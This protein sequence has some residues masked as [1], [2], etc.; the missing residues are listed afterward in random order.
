MALALAVKA[1]LHPI[2]LGGSQNWRLHRQFWWGVLLILILMLLLLLLLLWLLAF[3]FC[4]WLLTFCSPP[5]F[6]WGESNQA[7]FS[8]DL[9]GG[10]LMLLL[11][12][13]LAFDLAFF[14]IHAK[15]SNGNI[16]G[17]S[18]KQHQRQK[19]KATSKAKAKGNPTTPTKAEP[20]L[21][22]RLC[23]DSP[24]YAVE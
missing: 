14:L 4:F 12:F 1:L 9:V 16:K 5:C 15:K 24:A 6:I 2:F 23:F 7:A 17:K 8:P 13:D 18:E 19:R 11:A 10:L 20:R 21:S 3:G 22:A